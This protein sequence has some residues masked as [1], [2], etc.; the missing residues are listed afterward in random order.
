VINVLENECGETTDQKEIQKV[1]QDCESLQIE[2]EFHAGNFLQVLT[3]HLVKDPNNDY[4][5]PI[6]YLDIWYEG[7]IRFSS[8]SVFQY[9]QY[10]DQ[11]GKFCRCF[12]L[13]M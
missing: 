11:Y 12:H 6:Y 1:L 2:L 3:G 7:R 8:G 9:R 4:T 13:F 5:I 10:K